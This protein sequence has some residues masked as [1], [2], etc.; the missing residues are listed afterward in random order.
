MGSSYI[1]LW[2]EFPLKLITC[3]RWGIFWNKYV[4]H[5]PPRHAC[6]KSLCRHIIILKGPLPVFKIFRN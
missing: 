1:E 6:I 4:L 3:E 2:E 5:F